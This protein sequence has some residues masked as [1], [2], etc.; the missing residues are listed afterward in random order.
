MI[1][2]YHLGLPINFFLKK[3]KFVSCEF[4]TIENLVYRTEISRNTN[5]E[6]FIYNFFRK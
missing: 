4:L 2:Q 5:S 6:N 1:Y 3:N